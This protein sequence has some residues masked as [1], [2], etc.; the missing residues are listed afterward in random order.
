[1]KRIRIPTRLS[2][3][4]VVIIAALVTAVPVLSGC[5]TAQAGALWGATIGAL[6]GHDTD[7]R[8]VGSAVG[9]GVGYMIGSEA[10]RAVAERHRYYGGYGH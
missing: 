4:R 9:A 1:M 6:L 5:T 2:L 7:S 3:R 10:D 8:L